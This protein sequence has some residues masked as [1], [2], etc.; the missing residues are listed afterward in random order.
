MNEER[1]KAILAGEPGPLILDGEDFYGVVAYRERYVA[2]S[3]GDHPQY[4]WVN[5]PWF[6]YRHHDEGWGPLWVYEEADGLVGF[7]RAQSEH[8][9]WECVTDEIL[10]KVDW[11]DETFQECLKDA[12]C[13]EENGEMPEGYTWNSSGE[14]V[15]ECLNGSQLQLLTHEWFERSGREGVRLFVGY[16]DEHSERVEKE[17]QE[18]KAKCSLTRSV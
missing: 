4:T 3:G 11:D 16:G 14:V 6:S 15:S 12:G 8:E 9:A 10:D 18:A 2:Y 1:A 17:Y 13:T 5:E 7:V